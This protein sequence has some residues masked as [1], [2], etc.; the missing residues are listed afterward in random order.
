MKCPNCKNPVGDNA[1]VCEWCG[2]ILKKTE[3]SNNTSLDAELLALLEEGN[4]IQ[5]VNYYQETTGK[6]LKESQ[7]YVTKSDYFRTHKFATEDAWQKYLAQIEN[8]QRR[9]LLGIFISFLFWGSFLIIM[10]RLLGMSMIDD[11]GFIFLILSGAL[12]LTGII[13]ITITMIKY[14]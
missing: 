6:S 2:N 3:K 11:G 12:F 7:L 5:A 1:I 13:G 14:K 9:S 4:I 10:N 8:K